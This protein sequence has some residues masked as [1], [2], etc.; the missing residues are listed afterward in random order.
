MAGQSSRATTTA[1]AS[2][3]ATQFAPVL[4][5][6]RVFAIALAAISPTTSVFLVYGDGLA[7]VGTGIVWA[8]V[9]AAVVAISMAFAYA[10]LGS[11]H[12]GA[13]GAYTFIREVLGEAFGFVGLLLFLVLGV[14]STAAI[15]VASATYLHELIGALPVNWTA[16]VMMALVT[17]LSL[18]RLGS[19]SWVATVMLVVELVVILAF[20]VA[21]LLS[22]KHGLGFVTH[23]VTVAGKGS[24]LTGVGFTGLLPAVALALFAYNGYDW[25]LYFAEETHQPRRVLPRAV[26]IAEPGAEV[27]VRL[28]GDRLRAA[29][30]FHLADQAHHVHQRDHR[31]RL[32]AHRDGGDREPAARAHR[33]AAVSHAPLA[34]PARRGHHRHRGRPALP[35]AQRRPHHRGRRGRRTPLLARLPAASMSRQRR[36]SS[37]ARVRVSAMKVLRR[38]PPTR[39]SSSAT[40]WSR[41]LTCSRMA[42]R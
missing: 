5:S 17:G 41:T 18:E 38:H 35:E 24:G 27:V 15:L 1:P 32:P 16:V 33:R 20:I 12:Q 4:R 25:P 2:A 39:R 9:L 3:S 40:R 22:V 8:F 30:L 19:S 10:E 11:V 7:E 14:I 21:C 31:H 37:R 6:F 23:P 29:V 36:S 13:G 34:G 26:L 28:P 42:T